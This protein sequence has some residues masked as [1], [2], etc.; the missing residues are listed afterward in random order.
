MLQIID[1]S[2]ALS[3]LAVLFLQH[4]AVVEGFLLAV[5]KPPQPVNLGLDA[6]VPKSI[7]GA[8]N[9]WVKRVQ[10]GLEGGKDEAGG[11]WC[12][13]GESVEGL[14]VDRAIIAHGPQKHGL[15]LVETHAQILG[16]HLIATLVLESEVADVL[17]RLVR[18]PLRAQMIPI[19]VGCWW[20]RRKRVMEVW[21]RTCD[22]LHYCP[23]RIPHWVFCGEGG[24][25]VG[26]GQSCRRMWGMGWKWGAAVGDWVIG[27]S[28]A[29]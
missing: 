15:S 23:H 20:R 4:I 7:E 10:E 11:R 3:E 24:C 1:P 29:G 16:C 8:L 17:V 21:V 27:D 12:M 25:L 28:R 22:Y 26:R 6:E 18:V 14:R 13:E 2:L 5:N 9:A 19:V